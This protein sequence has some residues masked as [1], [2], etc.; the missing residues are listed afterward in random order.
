MRAFVVRLPS[1]VRYWTVLDDDLRPHPAADAFLQ[2]VRLGRDGAE[3]T[4]QA[5]ATGIALFLSWCAETGADWWDSGSRLGWFMTWLTVVPTALPGGAVRSRGPR[6]INAILAAVREF[7]KH[8][9]ATGDAP[10][11]M[12]TALYQQ[13]D[14]RWLPLELR[15]DS[16]ARV[17]RPR[18]RHRVQAPVTEAGPA[19][20]QDVLAVFRACGSAR[21]RFIV[22]A[23]SRLGLRRGE[24]AGLHREDVHAM[25]DS[26]ALRCRIR[27]EHL[28][29]RRR[30]DNQNRAWAKSRRD[31]AVPMDLVV[32]QAYDQY[33]LE[34]N[35]CQTAAD[36]DFLLVNLFRAPVGAPMRVGA[37][38]ELL[39]SLSRRAGLDTPIHPHMLRH[40]FATNLA[41]TGAALD[42][43]QDL[44]GHANPASTQVYFH[45]SPDRLR[46]AVDRVPPP[47]GQRW[48]TSLRCMRRP[49]IGLLERKA[50]L[51]VSTR[52]SITT[53][54]G[55]SAGMSSRSSSGCRPDIPLWAGN[56]AATRCARSWQ[57]EGSNGRGSAMAAT[58]DGC[59]A[60]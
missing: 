33:L 34:R 29:V 3:S 18:P 20:D 54:C 40:Q 9:V 19:T 17:S 1:G 12:L 51:R 43:T 55:E 60:V 39:T 16:G 28:H 37:F 41:A 2:H 15:R 52:S 36:C 31:R 53:S 47:R 48:L 30:D 35:E 24:L 56:R 50:A 8:A 45:P 21:D 49:P 23:L 57:P 26:T 13:D 5:Y 22:L 27:Q 32:V 42:E 4:T 6:R 7:A 58:F 44:L 59:P 11:S 10:P 46:D 14:D 25:P 38:N